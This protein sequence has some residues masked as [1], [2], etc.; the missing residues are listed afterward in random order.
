[1]PVHPH[2]R[3]IWICLALC[4]A[5]WGDCPKGLA[6]LSKKDYATAQKEFTASAGQGDACSQFNLSVMYDQALGVPQDYNEALKWLR[7]AADQGYAEAQ[8]NLGLRY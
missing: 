6:A 2:L 4:P 1:M 5:I 3:G 7:L 8:R